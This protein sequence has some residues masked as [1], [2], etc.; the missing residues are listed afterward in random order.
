MRR[1]RS[2]FPFVICDSDGSKDILRL[3]AKDTVKLLN[4]QHIECSCRIANKRFLSWMSPLGSWLCLNST[5]ATQGIILCCCK[6]L[7]KVKV[8]DMITTHVTFNVISS[9]YI[10]THLHMAEQGRDTAFI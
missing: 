10:G 1:R 2:W 6:I 5:Q 7:A 3:K 8:L 4:Q 9:P